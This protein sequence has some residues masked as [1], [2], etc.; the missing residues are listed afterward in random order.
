MLNIATNNEEDE[1]MI[2]LD[3]DSAELLRLALF[4][5]QYRQESRI[6]EMRDFNKTFAILDEGNECYSDEDKLRALELIYDAKDAVSDLVDAVSAKG[7]LR[8]EN[9]YTVK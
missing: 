6:K 8:E 7:Y 9:K 2:T 4:A 5:L 3:K 1:V